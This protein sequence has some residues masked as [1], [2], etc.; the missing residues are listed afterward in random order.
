[1][2]PGLYTLQDLGPLVE[3]PDLAGSTIEA[4]NVSRVLPG[5]TALGRT[6]LVH[7]D[8]AA[9]Q[10]WL[11]HTVQ[12]THDGESRGCIESREAQQQITALRF[13]GT[14]HGSKDA[15]D[16]LHQSLAAPTDPDI[17]DALMTLCAG[18]AVTPT[19]WI[20]KYAETPD[21]RAAAWNK[22]LYTKRARLGRA[23]DRTTPGALYE[24]GVEQ[25]IREVTDGELSASATL[26]SALEAYLLSTDLFAKRQL[27]SRYGLS[28]GEYVSALDDSE[29]SHN[30]DL[31]MM[32]FAAIVN[33][34][35]DI[36]PEVKADLSKEVAPEV[37][38]WSD[39]QGIKARGLFELSVAISNGK[40]V[41]DVLSQIETTT[42]PFPSHSIHGNRDQFL[43][44]AAELYWRSKRPDLAAATIAHISSTGEWSLAVDRYAQAGGSLNLI[45]QADEMR[46]IFG[47][48]H[49][50]AATL[51]NP[52]M[53][54]AREQIASFLMHMSLPVP[55]V[56]QAKETILRMAAS[57]PQDKLGVNYIFFRPH[58]ERL[59][60]ADQDAVSLG[61]E[62][63]KRMSGAPLVNR[64]AI[65]EVFAAHGSPEMTRRGWEQVQ[66]Y[67][68]AP[69]LYFD[70]YAHM[71]LASAGVTPPERG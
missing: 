54:S 41:S 53:W 60:A 18:H 27:I 30:E 29:E 37:P 47:D 45:H 59:L 15:A 23:G 35:P 17:M 69:S 22:F 3:H 10:R 63:I 65:Y 1:M 61:P 58:L 25:F 67:R 38:P 68:H 2:W 21:N 16:Q 24:P 48:E 7:D 55:D 31:S 40:D 14:M 64:R 52:Q 46:Q 62:I 70:R 42:R 5:L 39:V 33:S 32:T 56:A 6:A 13:F 8:I 9:Y 28:I 71:A 12:F 20:N 57:M 26:G 4:H 34:D 43:R 19:A 51:H 66:D 44:Q 11:D 49:S 50:S 36:P